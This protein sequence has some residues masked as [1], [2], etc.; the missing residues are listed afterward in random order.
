MLFIVR[1]KCTKTDGCL[2]IHAESAKEAEELGWKR[3]M[4]V[5]EVTAI[6]DGSP[7]IGKLDRVAEQVWRAWRRTPAR[8]L[9]CFGKPVSSGQA[10]ALVLCGCTTWVLNLHTFGFVTF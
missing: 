4:F 8:A 9:R 10:A 2:R 3:G 6:E 5:T 1:G 7:Q